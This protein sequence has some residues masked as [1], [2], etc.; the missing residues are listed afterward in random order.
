M[1]IFEKPSS[2]VSGLPNEISCEMLAKA[3]RLKEAFK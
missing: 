3:V 2:T 1:R